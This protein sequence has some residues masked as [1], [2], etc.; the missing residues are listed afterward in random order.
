M[1][2]CFWDEAFHT[3]CFLI[4]HLPGRTIGMTTPLQQLFGTAPDYTFLRT[5]GC[6]RWP[7]LRPY[8]NRK[9]QFRSKRCVFLGY[10]SMH[11]GYKCLHVSSIRVYISRDVIFAEFFS[12]CRSI[13]VRLATFILWWTPA[14][15]IS[16]F[17]RSYCSKQCG[18]WGIFFHG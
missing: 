7:C 14:A 16:G 9:I 6:A 15:C 18:G 5:F 1:P 13:I 17:V 4:N 8:N 10:S 3:A 11:K 12:L 2:L